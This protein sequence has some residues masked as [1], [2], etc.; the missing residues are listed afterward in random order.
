MCVAF[1]DGVRI[2]AWVAPYDLG[3][4]LLVALA[5]EDGAS[6]SDA[7]AGEIL[8]HFCGVGPF[9]ETDWSPAMIRE[10]F[11][12]ARQWVALPCETIAQIPAPVA[13]PAVIDKPLNAHLRAVRKHLP[14]K[15]PEAWSVPVAVTE[16]QGNYTGGF[17]LIEQDDVAFIVTLVG[18][19]NR[20]K[21]AVTIF[22]PSGE[23]VNEACA[24]GILRHFRGVSEFAQC[25]DDRT[26]AG[27]RTYLGEIVPTAEQTLLS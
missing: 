16:P 8:P 23:T 24:Y 25:D 21:L 18:S 6:V 4:H 2:M 1:S 15:L 9:M 3:Y 11:P 27:A 13:P 19:L 12:H 10:R 17:W 26:I 20:A 5:R 14:A 7:R 22:F